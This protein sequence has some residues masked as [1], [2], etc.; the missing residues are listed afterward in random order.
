MA[1]AE[2]L[3]LANYTF[4][5]HKTDPKLNK[6]KEILLSNISVG[7]I[8]ELQNIVDSVYLTRDLVNQPFSH[9]TAADLATAAQKV[10]RK[11]GLK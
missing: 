8:K 11:M 2:G 6:L 7:E 9:L 5:Q 3:A 10:G 1:I 4:T